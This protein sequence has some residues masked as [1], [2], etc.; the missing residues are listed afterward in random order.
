MSMNVFASV[1]GMQQCALGQKK[2]GHRIGLIPTMGFLHEG[3]LSLVALARKRTDW[4]VLSIFVN[5]IQFMPGEDFLQYPRNF[6]RDEA[7]CEQAGVDLV[8]YPDQ[9]EMYSTDHSVFVEETSL[10]S[11]ICGASRPGHFKGV[12]TVVA[13]LFNIVMP[14][15]AVFGQK[16]AQ[17]CRVIQRM[18][19]DLNINVEIVVG[20]IV[21]EPDGLAM[22]SRNR[23]LSPSGRKKALCLRHSL[24]LAEKMVQA[25]ER[26]VSVIQEAVW[27]TL[28]SEPEANIDYVAFLDHETL[29]PVL[30]IQRPVLLALAVRIGATRLIDNTVLYSP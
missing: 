6:E 5:P 24:D 30:L 29:T 23:Y 2:A 19:R 14:D 21:R 3:H 28:S 20:P 10:S 8:F 1:Q 4:V 26:T 22:S 25:G 15:V 9:K 13:K 16:D 7:L 27:A 12:T 17:Q 18:V 11:G